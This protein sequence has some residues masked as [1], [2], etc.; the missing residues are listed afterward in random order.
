[1]IESFLLIVKRVGD[2]GYALPGAGNLQAEYRND[3][4]EVGVERL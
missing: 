1:M 3:V 2:G 4:W